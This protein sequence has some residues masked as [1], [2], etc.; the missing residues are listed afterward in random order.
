MYM[1]ILMKRLNGNEHNIC[2]KKIILIKI[3]NNVIKI[4]PSKKNVFTFLQEDHGPFDIHKSGSAVLD[5]LEK[6]TNKQHEG[7]HVPSD[8]TVAFRKVC[9]N[10]PAY[11]VCRLFLSTLQLVRILL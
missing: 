10:K 6:S 2:N 9:T 5:C 8:E 4:L 7:E 1:K 3:H 11:E